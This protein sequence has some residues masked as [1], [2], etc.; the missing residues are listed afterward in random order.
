MQ[1][2][3]QEYLNDNT[4]GE[5][6]MTIVLFKKVMQRKKREKNKIKNIH[7]RCASQNQAE[8]T[9]NSKIQNQL[10]DLMNVKIEISDMKNK[11]GFECG[12]SARRILACQLRKQCASGI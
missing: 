11:Y 9:N 3:I 10:P 8:C 6:S 5:N 12:D 4:S 7:F 1:V 2:K